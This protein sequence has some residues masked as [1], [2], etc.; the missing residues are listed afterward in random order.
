[1][2]QKVLFNATRSAGSAWRLV[3]AIAP[4]DLYFADRFHGAK[5]IASDV[6]LEQVAAVLN[7]PVANA[8]FD[9]HCRNRKV[10][11][12]TLKRLPF[13]KLDDNSAALLRDAV[14]RLSQ[15]V[16]AKWRQAREGMFYDGLSDTTDAV[17]LLG[18]IDRIVY[19]AYGLSDFERR[20]ID[21]LMAS[22][23][24]PS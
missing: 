24:R 7:S 23:S 17:R 8:W 4:A 6:S 14:T 20:Q 2:A 21:K 18:E 19:D 15:A 22:E 5:P 1:M 3:A 11:L 13:P 12:A 9:A 16:I 10:V